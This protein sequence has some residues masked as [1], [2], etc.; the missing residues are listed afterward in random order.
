MTTLNANGRRSF[1]GGEDATNQE[2]RDAAALPFSLQMMRSGKERVLKPETTPTEALSEEGDL[3]PKPR[4]K[5]TR[6][7]GGRREG[8]LISSAFETC[9]G[10]ERMG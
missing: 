10:W 9:D 8:A 4:P 1:G 3:D 6:W 7:E 5:K 2:R